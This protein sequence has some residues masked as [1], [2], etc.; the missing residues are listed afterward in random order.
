MAYNL[1]SQSW[2]MQLFEDEVVKQRINV[3]VF[4]SKHGVSMFA[5]A[6]RGIISVF[7]LY[8]FQHRAKMQQI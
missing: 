5:A 3:C 8:L 4:L 1:I 2:L 7:M 6:C